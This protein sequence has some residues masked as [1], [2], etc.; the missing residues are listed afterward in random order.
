MIIIMQK[1]LKI[2]LQDKIIGEIYDTYMDCSPL[3]SIHASE[4]KG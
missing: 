4:P 3:A 1:N 2:V